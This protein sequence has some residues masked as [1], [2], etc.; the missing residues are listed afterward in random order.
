V[1]LGTLHVPKGFSGFRG[2]PHAVFSVHIQLNKV[3]ANKLT[4]LLR[5]LQCTWLQQSSQ[6]MDSGVQGHGL[7]CWST[8]AFV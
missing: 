4:K 8:E 5:H 7:C 6:E 3:L 2:V 1:I